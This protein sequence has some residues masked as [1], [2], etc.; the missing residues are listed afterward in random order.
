LEQVNL[1]TFGGGCFWC[2]EPIFSR[3]KG[4][5]A[6]ESG[7]SGGQTENPSYEEVCSGRTGHAEVVQ[8]KYDPNIINFDELLLIFFN[9]H[10]PTTLNRQGYDVGTQYRSAIFFHSEEQKLKSEDFINNLIEK[11]IFQNIVTEI[12]EF[13]KFYKAEEYHQSYYDKNPGNAYC[14]YNIAPKIKKFQSGFK[15]VLIK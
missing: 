6:P 1:A 9:I 14:R 12:S 10:D 2:I 8:I 5:L 4:V 15:N 7:Y 3:I 11:K 13:M